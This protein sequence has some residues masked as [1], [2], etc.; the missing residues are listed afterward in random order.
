MDCSPKKCN[1]NLQIKD[2][3]ARSWQAQSLAVKKYSNLLQ[4]NWDWKLFHHIDFHNA[5]VR[6]S[7]SCVL[8]FPNISNTVLIGLFEYVIFDTDVRKG[9]YLRYFFLLPSLM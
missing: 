5:H 8:I 6:I 1:G 7:I 2:R 9:S 4:D 3:S